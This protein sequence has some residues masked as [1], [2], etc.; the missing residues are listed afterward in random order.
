MMDLLI[1]I[2]GQLRLSPAEH[3][4]QVFMG[5][6]SWPVSYKANQTLSSLGGVSTVKLVS[7]KSEKDKLKTS[8]QQPFEVRK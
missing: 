6:S 7:K 1:K 3:S 2:C 8:T 5:D 4:L